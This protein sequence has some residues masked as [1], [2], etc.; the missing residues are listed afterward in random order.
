LL[1]KLKATFP[2]T[3]KEQQVLMRG[4]N[5]GGKN[6]NRVRNASAYQDATA[7][8][9]LL[10]YLYISDQ[11]RCEELLSWLHMFVDDIE[12]KKANE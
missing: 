6:K 5:A 10:G 11:R 1:T 9:A 12:P 4:R 8:E 2:L 7:F 3:N